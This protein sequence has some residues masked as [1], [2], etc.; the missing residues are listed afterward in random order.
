M[1]GSSTAIDFRVIDEILEKYEY[2]KSYLI[3]MLQAVQEVYNYLPEEI[4]TFIKEYVVKYGYPPTIREIG[5]AVGTS[6]PATVHVHLANI[7]N[8]GFIK[9][10][11]TKNR[12][13]EIL[14]ESVKS[15]QKGIEIISK[16]E[17]KEK[18]FSIVYNASIITIKILKKK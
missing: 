5:A 7:E 6:S 17:N 15:I 12:A 1:S 10:Q 2:K 9:R 8:K 18:Y 13:I 16:P 3:A 14:V 11:G 4:L